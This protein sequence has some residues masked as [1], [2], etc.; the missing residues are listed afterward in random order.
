MNFLR[1]E[2]LREWE[3]GFALLRRIPSTSV[4]KFVDYFSALDIPDQVALPDALAQVALCQFFSS[5]PHPA[6]SGNVAFKRYVDAMPLMWDWKYMGT[7]ELRAVLAVA[8]L[9]PDSNWARGMTREIEE[10]IRSIRCTSNASDGISGSTSARLAIPD[11]AWT[12]D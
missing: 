10:Q 12:D 5:A 2:F 1:A 3:S 9:E 6:Q 4:R 7:R 11:A 8:K